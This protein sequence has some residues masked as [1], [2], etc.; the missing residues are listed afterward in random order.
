MAAANQP[1]TKP[2]DKRKHG[3]REATKDM[4][5]T[6]ADDCKLVSEDFDEEKPL[7]ERSVLSTIENDRVNRI[8]SRAE[9]NYP[10]Q[11]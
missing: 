1:P 7:I 3:R 5:E 6:S 10:T 2:L 4:N 9:S 8:S 11:E